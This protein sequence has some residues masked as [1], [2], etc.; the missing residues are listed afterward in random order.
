MAK[1]PLTQQEIDQIDEIARAPHHYAMIDVPATA[2]R[3]QIDEAYRQFAREWHPDRFFSRDVG[4]LSTV[5]EENFIRV[6]RGYNVLRDERQRA[7]YDDELRANGAWPGEE[8]PATMPSGHTAVPTSGGVRSSLRSSAPV[9]SARSAA[10]PAPTAVPVPPPPP[11]PEGHEVVVGPRSTPAIPRRPAVPPVLA[12]LGAQMAEQLGRA[13]RYYEAG[14]E[15][16]DAGRFAKAESNLYLATRYDPKNATY[17][18][19]YADAQSRARVSRADQL[20]AQADQ[21]M[22]VGKI[23]EATALLRKAVEADGPSGAPAFKLYQLLVKEGD[24]DRQQ[25]MGLLRKA[26]LKEPKN[27]AYR[28]AL[29]EL[30]LSLEMKVNAAREVQ[31]ALEAEPGNEA[32]KALLKKVKR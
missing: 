25:L 16:Y 13:T 20:T 4:N 6:T 9:S 23:V 27:V 21:S 8:P 14:K 2:P 11:E 32:A 30:Y 10:A 28:L 12:R 26:V 5:I 29:A 24:T 31:T 17:Q 19:L 15:D 22:E 7:A 3:A 1:R 18:K